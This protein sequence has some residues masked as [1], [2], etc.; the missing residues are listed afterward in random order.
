MD[1]IANISNGG[2]AFR[3]MDSGE[4]I[5]GSHELNIIFPESDIYIKG[6]VFIIISDFYVDISPFSTILMRQCG[7]KFGDLTQ[8]QKSQLDYFNANHTIDKV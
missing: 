4:N 1:R 6:I 2:L 3:Y 8:N 5:Q 7:G